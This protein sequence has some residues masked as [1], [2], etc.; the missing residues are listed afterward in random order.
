MH[1][2]VTPHRRDHVQDV[3]TNVRGHFDVLCI[4]LVVVGESHDVLW[5]GTHKGAH[6]ELHRRRHGHTQG[7]GVA[8]RRKNCVSA[9]RKQRTKPRGQYAN[10]HTETRTRSRTLIAAYRR[11][12]TPPMGC[13]TTS[14][15]PAFP[16]PATQRAVR[17]AK[18]EVISAG[19]PQH[20]S[21]MAACSA[22]DALPRSSSTTTAGAAGSSSD[23]RSHTHACVRLT[24]SSAME[25]RQ[26]LTASPPARH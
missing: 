26:P 4:Q 6:R 18:G 14:P 22:S 19:R 21:L 24:A 15:W 8:Q 20:T 16:S 25:P 3:V 17:C 12:Q 10:E 5:S 1:E 13:R 2:R 7:E 11:P 23:L 9:C